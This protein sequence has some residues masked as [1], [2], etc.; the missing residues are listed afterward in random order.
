[1][2]SIKSSLKSIHQ[3]GP[4]SDL[5][6]KYSKILSISDLIKVGLLFA[7]TFR[8][9]NLAGRQMVSLDAISPQK[10]EL[11][12]GHFTILER[13]KNQ[14]KWR[15]N[16]PIF[17]TFTSFYPLHS[18]FGYQCATFYLFEN[19]IWIRKIGK[20]WEVV[21]KSIQNLTLEKGK[22]KF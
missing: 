9:L 3:K 15:Q 13:T 10:L 6:R 16:F 19:Y 12:S 14:T 20:E 4:G 8:S 7:K 18:I 2:E 11:F 21:T 22:S 17:E 1:M 5:D